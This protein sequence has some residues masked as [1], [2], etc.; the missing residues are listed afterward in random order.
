MGEMGEM[1]EMKEMG[2]F[3]VIWNPK[4]RWDEVMGYTCWADKE[5]KLAEP[6][7]RGSTVL[8]GRKRGDQELTTWQPKITSAD[9]LQHHVLPLLNITLHLYPLRG[10]ICLY[11]GPLRYLR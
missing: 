1:E 5:P 9:L 6:T 8:K 2:E 11:L 3:P 7:H 10:K 4:K